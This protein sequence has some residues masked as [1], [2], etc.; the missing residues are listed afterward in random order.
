[1]NAVKTNNFIRPIKILVGLALG[2][3][4]MAAVAMPTTGYADSPDRPLISQQELGYPPELS[5]AIIDAHFA[6]EKGHVHSRADRAASELDFGYPPELLPEIIDA[7]F[8]AKTKKSMGNVAT[9]DEE[10]GYPPELLPEVIDRRFEINT[11]WPRPASLVRS[12]IEQ[13]FGYPP[14]LLPEVID[15]RFEINTG[16]PRPASLVQASAK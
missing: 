6:G 10:F 7:H 1:M 4:V 11:G 9:M 8:A 13:G 5:P 3:M 14:E 2:A 16:W 15:R 12:S